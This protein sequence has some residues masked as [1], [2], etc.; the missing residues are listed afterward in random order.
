MSETFPYIESVGKLNKLN[1]LMSEIRKG[2]VPKEVND[3]WFNFLD[4]N[5]E[6]SS[7]MFQILKF[8]GFIDD[9]KKPT[10]VWIG[11]KSSKNPKKALAKAIKKNYQELFAK[12]PD[13]HTKSKLELADYFR[14]NSSLEGED[15]TKAKRTFLSLCSLGRPAS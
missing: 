11:Y 10:S 15:I 5:K 12:F 6:D 9:A 3:A 8:T 7:G 4:L 1:K 2:N 14:E 13:A